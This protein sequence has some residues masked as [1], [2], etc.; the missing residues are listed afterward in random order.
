ML[1]NNPSRSSPGPQ[2]STYQMT[3]ARESSASGPC[4]YSS[5]PHACPGAPYDANQSSRSH[6]TSVARDH[7]LVF[8]D[9]AEVRAAVAEP[10]L[11]GLRLHERAK[12][13][14]ACIFSAVP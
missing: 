3:R 2:S 10:A 13:S 11:V 14:A 12:A 6:R 1:R 4:R 8:R 7:D 9:P 5:T